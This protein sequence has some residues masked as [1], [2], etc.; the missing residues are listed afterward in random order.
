MK[1]L[2]KIF[3]SLLLVFIAMQFYRPEKNLSQGAHTAPFLTE[4][5]PPPTVKTILQ[6]T[7]YD[8]HSNNTDYPWYN[9]IAP[10][11]FW[12][13]HHIDKGKEHL[14]FSDWEQYSM[15]QK[16]HKLEELIEE[17][18]EGKMPLKE[19]TWTH[20]EAIL[21][22]TQIDAI[23]KWAEKTRILYQLGKQPN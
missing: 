6:E 11:S 4:T 23:T 18:S 17:V 8:C 15:K 1:I 7:C 12:L 19:Y 20:K 9:N 22:N 10:V 13:K 3:L 5:N 2:K 16:D 14:N 21:S